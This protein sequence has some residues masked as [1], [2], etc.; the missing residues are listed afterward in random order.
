LCKRKADINL[1]GKNQFN[2][3]LRAVQHAEFN[4][5]KYLLKQ[6]KID[7]FATIVTKIKNFFQFH[8]SLQ[9]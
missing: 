3:L 4:V 5:V 6:P 7:V 1:K 8:I 2:P 9:I